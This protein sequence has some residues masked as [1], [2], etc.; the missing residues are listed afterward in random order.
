MPTG[1][2][3]IINP[4]TSL[5]KASARV[6]VPIYMYETADRKTLPTRADAI[7]RVHDPREVRQQAGAPER[8]PDGRY[9]RHT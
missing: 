9:G 4:T 6:G 3:L 1:Q 7:A 2:P 8:I 5:L